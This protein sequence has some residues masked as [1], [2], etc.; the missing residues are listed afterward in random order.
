MSTVLLKNIKKLFKNF[1]TFCG[2][3][4]IIILNLLI[5]FSSI[6]FFY[7]QQSNTKIARHNL[8][9]KT[10]QKIIY[11]LHNYHGK[12]ENVIG[13]LNRLSC[14]DKGVLIFPVQ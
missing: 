2:Y 1:F 4:R 3:H 9:V 12:F 6:S 7:I 5:F 8:I 14:V 10:T 13:N 11:N